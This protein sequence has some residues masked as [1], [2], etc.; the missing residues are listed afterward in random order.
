MKVNKDN[1]IFE[2]DLDSVIQP[3]T[4]KDNQII[5]ENSPPNKL[6]KPIINFSLLMKFF[7]IEE[8]FEI[9][10]YI[11]L[12]EPIL[13][14]SNNIQYLT[15]TI[16]GLLS[17]IYP[18]EY[19]FPVVSVLPEENYCF[20]NI[21]KCFI[22]GINQKYSDDIFVI[23]GINLDEQKNV[24]IIIIENRFNNILN[25]NEKEKSKTSVILNIK[26]NNSKL[27]KVSQIYLNNT[28]MEIKEKY[29]KRKN[30][31]GEM[32][33][34]VKKKEEEE[35]VKEKIEYNDD[36]EKRIKLPIHYYVKCCKRIESNCESKF[37]ELKSKLR[38]QEKDKNKF[39]KIFEIEKEKLFSNELIENF[40]YFFTSIFLHYQ[41]FCTK[42]QF[43]YVANNGESV[44]ISKRIGNNYR[45]G[46]Y[47]RTNELEK[48]YYSNKLTINDLFNCQLFIDEMPILDKPFYEKF[49]QTRIF[50]NFMK[51]K[52][53]PLSLQDKLDI[54]FFDEKINEK[55][56]RES[57]IKKIETKFL[58]YDISNISGDVNA[59]YLSRPISED[60]KEY[61]SNKKNRDKALNY[62]QYI[63]YQTTDIEEKRD[64]NLMENYFSNN[65]NIKI[66]FYYFVF[67]KLLNDGL[68]Y[69]KKKKKMMQVI[70]G[71]RLE[72]ISL[73]KIVIA[74]IINLKKKEIILLLMRI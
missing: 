18:F 10:K 34:K 74:F 31:I 40:F 14:F 42:F 66:N 9:I 2:D 47:F 8:I 57:G 30:L 56:S 62:F 61:L 64:G 68:F 12:E 5:F 55:L 6:L 32:A 49:F 21:Y 63:T 59:G 13:F 20:I 22:F 72:L 70:Y 54:L 52:I 17:L 3:M 24:N 71:Q 51:K 33:P 53:F 48:K 1:F 16:E 36:S 27:L 4:E 11:I 25:S 67:P 19:H 60:I 23:K 43:A 58:E 39:L 29:I 7:K 46:H 69:N 37:K 15:Y 38:E 44:S 45:D 26:P 35:K 28:I 50:F 41:E 65:S 73:L